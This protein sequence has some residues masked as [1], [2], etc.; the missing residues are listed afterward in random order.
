[1]SETTT[2]DIDQDLAWLSRI[3][4]QRRL[5]MELA[6]RSPPAAFSFI[7]GAVLLLFLHFMYLPDYLIYICSS[8]II[9][10]SLHRFYIGNQ[11]VKM[12]SLSSSLRNWLYTSITINTTAWSVMFALLMYDYGYGDW[13][14]LVP[15]M[16]FMGYVTAAAFTLC[17]SRFILYYFI[18]SWVLP[19]IFILTYKQLTVVY[20]TQ[21][22]AVY[23][24]MFSTVTIYSL[25]QGERIRKQH[26]DKSL[27][28]I[29]LKKANKDL[30]ESQ[31]KIIEQTSMT[32]HANRLSFLG[33]M[34]SGVAHEINNPLAI[35][36]G[37]LQRVESMIRQPEMGSQQK[38]LEIISKARNSAERI[39]KI[40]ESLRSLAG[41]SDQE[42]LAS[43][44][45]SEII[46]ETLIFCQSK[47][48][49]HGIQILIEC[50][51]SLRANCR[52]VQI[53]QILINLIYNALD[54]IELQTEASSTLTGPSSERQIQVSAQIKNKFIEIV[55]SNPGPEITSSIRDKI[56]QPFFTTKKVGKGTGLG[57]SIS[58]GI[59][60]QHGGDL[61]YR[62]NSQQ[63]LNEFCLLIP[64][65]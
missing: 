50:P 5:D 63:K 51:E 2:V 4:L 61:I 22:F 43:H 35:V 17:Y 26:I 58:K 1:M 9:I 11:T 30:F 62:H 19:Q 27:S 14:S 20:P 45:V 48:S 18:L 6:L 44:S 3:E 57:L 46:N 13:H 47:L 24:F 64:L 8:V 29:L 49:A 36:V 56:F 32:Q 59:A 31:Q 28:D 23:L 7:S 15:M 60:S 65:L 54:A 53:S 42:P 10:S 40:V 55:V 52:P 34:A 33:E 37:N 16:V 39:A 38:Q 25:R 41:Q 21:L 12:Q